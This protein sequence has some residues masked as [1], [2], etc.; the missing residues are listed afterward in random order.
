MPN[1]AGFTLESLKH[2]QEMRKS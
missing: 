1:A 2:F